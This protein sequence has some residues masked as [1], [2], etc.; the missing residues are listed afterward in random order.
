MPRTRLSLPER[1]A[2]YRGRAARAAGHQRSGARRGRGVA[3]RLPAD[4]AHPRK[5]VAQRKRPLGVDDARAARTTTARDRPGAG[6]VTRLP[7]RR[8]GR[9][10]TSEHGRSA[11]RQVASPCRGPRSHQQTGAA[12]ISS[13]GSADG[14]IW[15]AC[16]S[17]SRPN[18][19]QKGTLMSQDFEAFKVNSLTGLDRASPVEGE[20]V[21]DPVRSLWNS[22]ML[23]AAVI[24]GPVTFSWSGLAVFLVPG[25][26][27]LC[28]GHSVG[29]HRRLIHRS[30]Q[31]PKWLE[32]LLIYLG[33]VVGM[34]GPIWTIRLHDSRDWAQRQPNC[35]WFLRHGKPLL[36]DGFYYL[37]FRLK[38]KRPPGFEP[39]AG[40]ADDP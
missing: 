9:G 11:N 33:T 3:R 18:S 40:I 30:F 22:G 23:L 17:P 39:G 13:N 26:V 20:V 32:R 34:G 19:Q 4:R 31:C 6:V 28:A 16:R 14:R 10:K 7:A 25:G 35:H 15:R 24:L 38:L 1:Q 5:C 27:T 12:A 36:V 8:P 37:N 2:A 29:F 21:W